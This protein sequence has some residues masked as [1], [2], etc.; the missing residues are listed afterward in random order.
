MAANVQV[1]VET[2]EARPSLDSLLSHHGLNRK[3]LERECPRDVRDRVAGKFVDWKMVGRCFGF[4]A[5]KLAAIDR[6]NETEDQRRVALLDA[7]SKREGKGASYLRLADVL[8]RRERGDLVGLLCEAIRVSRA[9]P[10]HAYTSDEGSLSQLLTFI[11]C[12]CICPIINR[13]VGVSC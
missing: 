5:D 3:D 6:E 13:K 11:V 7:W 9:A 12:A 2:H 4:T 1:E 10:V 8:H